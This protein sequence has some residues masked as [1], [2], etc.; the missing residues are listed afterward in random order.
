MI[1]IYDVI[2]PPRHGRAQN[3]LLYDA[4]VNIICRKYTQNRR[5]PKNFP[6]PSPFFA[7]KQVSSASK[8][9]ICTDEHNVCCQTVN[10]V[11]LR[12]TRVTASAQLLK[13]HRGNLWLKLPRND[14]LDA[15]WG[16]K[17]RKFPRQTKSAAP[18][19]RMRLLDVSDPV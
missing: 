13:L 6:V 15:K 11:C 8:S 5:N 16:E 17:S 9:L 19:E 2:P 1:E 10:S 18:E 14:N 3:I 4:W 12:K 7:V